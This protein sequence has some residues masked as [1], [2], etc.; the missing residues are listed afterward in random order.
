MCLKIRSLVKSDLPT[1]STIAA[2]FSQN[3]WTQPV[4]ED[5]LKAGYLGWALET[6]LATEI[7]GF[8]IA[9]IQDAECQLMNIGIEPKYQC[10]GYAVYLLKELIV[11][12]QAVGV[13]YVSLEVRQSNK[14]AIG[15]YKKFGFKEIGLRKGYYPGSP[16]REDGLILFLNI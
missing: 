4:F 10:R 11:Y 3:S 14:A 16:K 15:L 5:C 7:V 8:L 6:E 9:L 13:V 2:Q 12:L 1:L